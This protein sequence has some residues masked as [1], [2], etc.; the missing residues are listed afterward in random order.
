[1]A[2]R[3]GK[4]KPDLLLIHSSLTPWMLEMA[5]ALPNPLFYLVFYF[6]RLLPE[7]ALMSPGQLDIVEGRKSMVDWH[8]AELVQVR[9]CYVCFELMYSCCCCGQ[10]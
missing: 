3:G 5:L 6:L 10:K 2:A 9:V 4:W 1:V 8:F 7:G